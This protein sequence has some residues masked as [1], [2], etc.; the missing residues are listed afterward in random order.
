M[1]ANQVADR[2]SEAP[3]RSWRLAVEA[4]DALGDPL[5][6]C[7][8]GIE[9]MFRLAA[10]LLE[11]LAVRVELAWF[12]REDGSRAGYPPH[13][14]WQLIR[15]DLASRPW[16][17]PA[18][19][20]EVDDIDRA[21]V[22]RLVVSACDQIGGDQLFACPAWI[23]FSPVTVRLL[24]PL[25]SDVSELVL[26]RKEGPAA[27][28]VERRAGAL[29]VSGPQDGF[30][31]PPVMT[32]LLVDPYQL[33][34]EVGAHWTPWSEEGRPGTAAVEAAVAHVAASGWELEE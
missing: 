10:G 12:D 34:L 27:L 14:E 3:L 31:T 5:A 21:A 6:M 32:R 23:A 4:P 7:R 16:P 33:R 18:T 1:G 15:R 13:M 22:E 24:D 25:G 29:W 19:R 26:G 28:P 30:V 2:E 20:E 9:A 11:P 8:P 17:V